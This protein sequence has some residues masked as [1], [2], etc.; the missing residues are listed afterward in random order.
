[1]FHQTRFMKCEPYYRFI[2]LIA[3]SMVTSVQYLKNNFA[4]FDCLHH[5]RFSRNLSDLRW[6]IFTESLIGREWQIARDC[7]TSN[8]DVTGWPVFSNLFH[9]FGAMMPIPNLI[10]TFFFV[11]FWN[12]KSRLS[13][14]YCDGAI[15]ILFLF[16]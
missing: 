6:S 10:F 4:I 11:L 13:R 5:S 1:M 16:E 3:Y 12:T 7:I 8:Q 2:I 15:N 9:A 14:F